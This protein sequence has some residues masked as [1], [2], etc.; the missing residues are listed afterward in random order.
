M[1]GTILFHKHV[2]NVYH[3]YILF[4]RIYSYLQVFF[5][6]L[7]QAKNSTEKIKSCCNIVIVLQYYLT[8][9]R[10]TLFFIQTFINDPAPNPWVGTTQREFFIHFV[11]LSSNKKYNLYTVFSPINSILLGLLGILLQHHFFIRDYN[12]EPYTRMYYLPLIRPLHSNT[13]NFLSTFINVYIIY[14]SSKSNLSSF[15]F[16]FYIYIAEQMR[17][18]IFIYFSK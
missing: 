8:R 9:S 12:Y 5:D 1:K 11:F 2:P 17:K 14:F 10:T 15:E 18:Y 16:F 4:F 7:H 6:S 3:Y 13:L